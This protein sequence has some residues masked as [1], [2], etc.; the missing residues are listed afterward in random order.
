MGIKPDKPGKPSPEPET[1]DYQIWIG[2]GLLGRPEDVVL[3]PYGEPEIN[4]LLV[5]DVEYSERWLP[6][7]TKGKYNIESWIVDLESVSP[8]GEPG[9]YCGTYIINNLELEGIL[10][11]HGID[12][13]VEAYAF[14]IAHSTQN[15][16]QLGENDYWYI[17]ISWQVGTLA[18]SYPDIPHLHALVGETNRDTEWG[19]VYDEVNDTWTVTFDNVEFWLI[20]NT[21]NY[22]EIIELWHGQLSFTVKI[23]RTVVES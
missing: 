5:K 18:P 21:E 11:A 14:R 6:P 12:S 2:N 1:F 4:Y 22:G 20:E 17:G 9:D 13:G 10:A 7:P 3:Q 8:E 16:P 15:H 23:T 19:G